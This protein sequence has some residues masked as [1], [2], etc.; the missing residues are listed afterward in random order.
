MSLEGLGAP[1]ARAGGAEALAV[2][3]TAG[4]TPYLRRTL[5]AL[6]RQTVAPEATIVVDVAS[7]HNGLGDGT[8]VEEI[9]AASALG[10]RTRV[11]VVRVPD[12]RGFGEAV[13]R[14][15]A[16]Y[17]E[18]TGPAGSS[19]RRLSPSSGKRRD[20]ARSN[21]PKRSY[22]EAGSKSR[23]SGRTGGQNGQ[24]MGAEGWLWLLHDD[25][26]PAPGCLEALLSAVAEARSA[27]L[28][29]PKQV[30]WD[31]PEQLLEVGLRTTASARR[32]NDVVAGEIDQGQH[33]DRSDVLA[34][35]TAGAL[36]DRAVWDELDGTSPEFPVFNDGLEL[37]RAIRL[38]GHR[39][40]VVPQAV[41]QHRRASYLGLRPSQRS[42]S[43]R[44]AVGEQ[45]SAP[46]VHAD[47]PDPDRSFRAR[48]T[49]QLTAWATFSHRPIALLLIWFLV[50]GIVR[51][52]A[53]LLT[54]SPPLARAELGA[55][56][57][58]ASRG[59][60]VRRGRKRLAAHATVR[61]SV[62]TR[63]Y[64]DAS[65]IRSVRRDRLRQ[66]RERVARAA[67]PSE[68]ELRELAALARR[69]RI[70][71]AGVLLVAVVVAGV[72]LSS[73][74]VTGTV[75]G[76]ATVGL[77]AT[78]RS[79]WSAA[80]ATWAAS[81]DGYTAVANPLLALLAL[82]V[83]VAGHVGLDG[84]GLVRL[85]FLAAVPLAA[86]GAWFA[87]G[88]ATRRTSL[89]A[90]AALT[91][92]LAPALLLAIGQGRLTAV[93]VHL[94][95]PWALT[96][97]ARAVGADRR[98]VVLSG[99]V[100]A[101]HATETEKA[102]LDRFASERIEDLAA[103]ADDGADSADGTDGTDDAG[104]VDGAGPASDTRADGD[105]RGSTNSDDSD[106]SGEPGDEASNAAAVPRERAIALARIVEDN[107]AEF[108]AAASP[109]DEVDERASETADGSEAADSSSV[110]PGDDSHG[111]HDSSDSNDG[112]GE[113]T[114]AATE[115]YGPGSPTAAAVAGIFLTLI[116]AA[117]P[118][119]AAVVVGCLLV[120]MVMVRR[121]ALRLV[122]TLLP[123]V[124]TAAPAWWRAARL[125]ST[126]GPTAGL[127]YLLADAGGP[128]AV[129]APS[130]IDTLLG[131]PVDITALIANPTLVLVSKAMLAIL[132]VT[133]LC[134]LLATGRRGHRAR[135][136]ALGA[137]GGLGLALLAVRAT[138]AIGTLPDGTGSVT[139]TGWAGTGITL[140]TAGL[141]AAGLAGADGIRAGLVRHDTH[142]AVWR[143]FVLTAVTLVGLV[144]PLAVG[145]G[146]AWTAHTS[147]GLGADATVM[148][149]Q[150]G[151]QRVPV[152][153]KEI[154]RS[155]SAGRVLALSSTPEGLAVRTWRGA[156]TQLTDVV[157]DVLA[158]QLRSRLPE[159]AG[160]A[161]PSAATSPAPAGKTLSLEPT[162]PADVELADI[163]TRATAGQ[164]EHAADDLAAH[165]IA[166]VLLADAPGDEATALARAGLESTPGLDQLTRT[167]AGTSWRVG[168]SGATEAA[169][170][171]LV[172]ADGTATTLATSADA[173]TVV[174]ADVPAAT[175]GQS[176]TVVLAERA[177]AGWTAKLNDSPLDPID[178]QDATGSWR[179]AFSMPPGG[180]ELVVSHQSTAGTVA[181]RLIWAAWA[182]TVLAALP[183]RRRRTI[184]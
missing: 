54:K 109:D 172:D 160:D 87:A 123:V 65:D 148:A 31:D 32:S 155:A 45:P 59:G 97:L 19:S 159:A 151:V 134:G 125:A 107:D 18:L 142:E 158:P 103:L 16:L 171:T 167:A 98:D 9:V 33:D 41:I 180:G 90:W 139:V 104:A 173:G 20:A 88:T 91:W 113:G 165:G 64:V 120:L 183:L 49:A 94:T 5:R 162:D 83:A 1:P 80:W 7:R 63:L 154:Q 17:A 147:T 122:L 81:G 115:S 15:L 181:A 121:S 14:G 128:V 175:D 130:A 114:T 21:R 169:R 13:R 28:V 79:L 95:L 157:P 164:D 60:A 40:V 30:D 163:V 177:D 99:M 182:I 27:A 76:G 46:Q 174:T 126:E 72:G 111:S 8:P 124:A 26:A 55:A 127:R 150:P 179:Q 66:E 25:V 152:I 82:P 153:A 6:A 11:R 141:L 140:L 43:R 119:T 68:L 84:D 135:A 86:L 129:P 101:H 176:R 93:L 77:T 75:T 4:V 39:V 118:S 131:M 50:L 52:G 146:W 35:G 184:A 138:T 136:G 62:L 42:T 144:V 143:R 132:P 70:V 85:L 73:L 24:N 161:D 166:V 149:L 102:D 58:V 57:A 178:V 105:S 51:A 37:S 67:A 3:V 48:R 110:T 10:A 116:V 38:A 47:D 156:G 168:P 53:R 89:R 56:L 112:D 61:R 29:G 133:A 22:D 74:L 78:G 2:V 34:V 96:A 106:D 69:R 92:A 170:A 137:L 108:G 145:A 117:A 71:L 23:A 44:S 12:A 100:D 36:V